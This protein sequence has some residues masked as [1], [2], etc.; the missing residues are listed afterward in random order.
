MDATASF[1]R[2]NLAM[3]RLPSAVCLS[4]A[5]IYVDQQMDRA[6]IEAFAASYPNLVPN[7]QLLEAP[8]PSLEEAY[9]LPWRRNPQGMSGESKVNLA[10]EVGDN[11]TQAQFEIEML[12]LY[13][14]IQR[15]WELAYE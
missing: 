5:Y 7:R 3:A 14:A 11:I 13:E 12:A 8:T 1:S 15:A 9:P 6:Q 4:Q 10:R 2:A